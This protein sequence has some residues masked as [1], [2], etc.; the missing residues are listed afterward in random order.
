MWRLP[1]GS[2]AGV[3]FIIF[4]AVG[5]H[6]EIVTGGT[7]ETLEASVAYPGEVQVPSSVFRGIARTPRFYRRRII[8]ITFSAGVLRIDRTDY[9]NPRISGLPLEGGQATPGTK[10]AKPQNL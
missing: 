10:A 6:L 5:D 9:R 2:E 4:R 8:T 3:N 7:S 1:D